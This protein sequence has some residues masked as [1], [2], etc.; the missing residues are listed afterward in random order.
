[1]KTTLKI[2][3]FLVVAFGFSATANAQTLSPAATATATLITPLTVAKNFDLS[4]ATV[5]SSG[6]AGA[7][8][9]DF[10]NGS[11]VSGGVSKVSGTPSTAQFT[12]TGESGKVFTLSYPSTIVLTN[13]T[14]N[15]T[16]TLSSDTGATGTLA[17]S[18]PFNKVIKMGGSLDIPANTNSGTYQNTTDLKITVNY[19]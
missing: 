14:D 9:V 4:F 12:V 15:L 16:L 19:Q 1:M 2:F 11:T 6:T 18:T 5:A 13:G 8:V 3:F 10:A 17:S 7:V